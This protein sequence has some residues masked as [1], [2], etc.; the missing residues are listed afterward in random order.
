MIP[1]VAHNT[2]MRAMI[3]NSI[4][5]VLK[6]LTYLR[7]GSP[8][9]LSET[10]HT[11]VDTGNQ[12]ILLVGLKEASKGSDERHPYGYGRN[13]FFWALVSA[14][15]LFWAGAGVTVYH[16]IGELLHP[17]EHLE[18]GWETWSI[19]GLSFGID[20]WVLWK[21]IEELYRTK[22]KNISMP[23]VS[24]YNMVYLSILL[25]YTK[26]N[27]LTNVIIIYIYNSLYIYSTYEKLLIHLLWQF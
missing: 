8:A 20:G 25:F 22:P 7:T 27:K 10:V 21:T 9:M 19:L 4:I 14:L 18:V 26:K 13:A 2:V 12:A 24:I 3:G 23:D 16:G 17:P 11:L 1:Q 6:F 15:G 5:T